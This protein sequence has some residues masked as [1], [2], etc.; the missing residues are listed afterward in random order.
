MLGQPLPHSG[1]P[2]RYVDLDE[3]Y[4]NALVTGL[5]Y[6]HSGG[7]GTLP[8]GLE[9]EIRAL[10]H[11]PL[12]WDAALARWFEE[13]VP[14]V[15]RRRSYA[16]ASRRQSATPDIPRPGWL[17]PEEMV[18]RATFGVVLDT[19]GSMNTRLLGKALGAI[20]SYATA[21]DV[22]RARVVFCDA[23]A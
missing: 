16:R 5:A 20:A 10:D 6:H 3:Y 19:S 22:P 23:V 15:E 21:R 7:R 8:A 14:A 9:Q 13:H 2:G 12:P 18:R 11:P 17:R 4:R 1:A